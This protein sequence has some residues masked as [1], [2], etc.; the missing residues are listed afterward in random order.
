MTKAFA[1]LLLAMT[2]C[3]TDDSGTAGSGDDA[4]PKRGEVASDPTIVSATV[5]CQAASGP[6]V[7][8][9]LSLQ[10]DASDPAGK[11]N[12]SSCALTVGS[13]SGQDDFYQASCY[14]SFDGM[15]CVPGTTYTLGIVVSNATGGVTTASVNVVATAD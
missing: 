10:V 13:M 11:T 15:P 4:L 9:R 7:P 14:V 1:I 5:E 8:Q 12:L 3:G 6:T 2:A